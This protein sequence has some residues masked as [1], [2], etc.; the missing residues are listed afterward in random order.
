M[1]SFS[2]SDD[3]PLKYFSN[4]SDLMMNS[5]SSCVA[6]QLHSTNKLREQYGCGGGLATLDRVQYYPNDPPQYKSNNSECRANH[7]CASGYC[8][9]TISG[10]PAQ[11]IYNA[12]NQPNIKIG[13]CT[14]VNN[15][16]SN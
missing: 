3:V 6:P 7:E 13:I 10:S 15:G 2:T 5:Y 16:V 4:P 11:N 12:Y 9:M 1:Q 14:D 8:N